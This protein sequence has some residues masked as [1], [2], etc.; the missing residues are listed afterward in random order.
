MLTTAI[1]GFDFPS[2]NAHSL[3]Q[4]KAHFATCFLSAPYVRKGLSFFAFK[5][6]GAGFD[7]APSTHEHSFHAPAVLPLKVLT[8]DAG[9]KAFPSE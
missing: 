7:G 1:H 3:V 5:G 8:I 9:G 2:L 6:T 4:T